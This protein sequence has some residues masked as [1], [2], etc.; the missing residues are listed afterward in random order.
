M[1]KKVFRFKVD[2]LWGI[3]MVVSAGLVF[4]SLFLGL[5]SFGVDGDLDKPEIYIRAINPG[6]TV[7]GKSNVG[8]LIEIGRTEDSDKL[9]SLAGVTV[10]YTN[11]SGS[12]TTLVEFPEHS[13]LSGETILLRLASSPDSELANVNYAKTLAFKAGPLELRR[14]EEVLD[15]VCWTGKGDCFDEFSSSSP[16]IL[17]REKY[18]GEMI[19]VSEYSP[20]FLE[21]NYYVEK[22]NEEE[23][24]VSQCKGLVFSEILSY[25]ESSQ[26]EQFIEFYNSSSEQILL[27]GCRIKYK[28]KYYSLSGIVKPEGYFIR[29]LNDFRL[30]KNPSS[31]NMIELIDANGEGV[32]RLE[33]PN[34]QRKGTSYAFIGY[35]DSGKEIWRV[36]YA[37][38]P[39]EPNNYQEFKS[40]PEGKVLNEETGNCV[41]ATVVTEKVCPAGQY[42]NLLT[43]RCRKIPEAEAE[44]TC[45]EGYE[46]NPE[47]NRCRK[48]KEN[49]GADYAL[50]AEEYEESSSFIAL[51]IVVGIILVAL[52]YVAYEFRREIFK[53]FK[54]RK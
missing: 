1:R 27:D 11:S 4:S 43:G 40:C 2:F 14:G 32:D 17:L 47:T 46:L 23:K 36:T 10:D 31:S 22:I 49:T 28:N 30:T 13:F 41:K 15:S 12:T 25:Y 50:E 20:E 29:L 37:P 6:Y 8:E 3:R 54:R 38:T 42:L 34:G 53:F 7:D 9:I 33:Y 44:K 48:I 45:K 39:G 24:G 35:D 5:P 26:S 51:Y 18:E 52:T 16:T 19:R 21:K